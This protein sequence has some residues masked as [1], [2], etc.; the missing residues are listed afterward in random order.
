MIRGESR[1]SGNN[2]FLIRSSLR[3]RLEE[4]CGFPLDLAGLPGTDLW[5]RNSDPMV[6]QN[7]PHSR[8]YISPLYAVV[9]HHFTLTGGLSLLRHSQIT[10][11]E[12]IC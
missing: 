2:V 4:S 3:Q 9:A 7:N 8:D 11:A 5:T 10:I 1:R 6:A 12:S